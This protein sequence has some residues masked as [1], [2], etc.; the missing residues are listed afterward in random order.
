MLNKFSCIGYLGD[1]PKL[2]HTSAGTAVATFSICVSEKYKTT[3][4]EEKSKALWVQC[5]AWRGTAENVA[6]H[7]KKGAM[8]YIEGPLEIS[9]YTDHDGSK[10]EV[11]EVTVRYI[12]FLRRAKDESAQG[13]GG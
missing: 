12:E 2:R 13:E 1:D 7:V 3:E 5:T 8:V 4:G 9:A 10:H 6:E 11:V